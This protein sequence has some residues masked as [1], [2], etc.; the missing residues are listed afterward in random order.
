MD[1]RLFDRDTRNV[2][3]TSA[4]AALLPV[5]ERL[6]GDFDHA[7]AELAQLFAGERGRLVIG[8][9]PS[10]AATLL[11]RLIKD[12]QASHP[13]VEIVVRD[14]LSGAL[15]RQFQERQIDLALI[16]LSQPSEELD[17]TPIAAEPFGLVCAKGSPLSGDGA[18]GWEVFT[19][20]P[21]IA[22]APLSSVR[23]TTDLAFSQVGIN[24][25]PLFECAHLATL[26]GLIEAGLGV[27]ALPKSTLP[28]LGSGPFEWRQLNN[29]SV[30][31]TIGLAKPARRSLSPAADAF[32]RY[33]A[34]AS[35]SHF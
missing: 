30:E 32:A 6:V 8:A 1:V 10:L 34:K 24:A 2:S 4:G 12:F 27:S 16:A 26:G 17:F 5:A 31:R 25:K 21:F 7:F 19:H 11:P 22:M 29:P 23:I 33:I 35:T 3:L 28:L 18:I 13:L 15:E 14:T 20:H 9:L